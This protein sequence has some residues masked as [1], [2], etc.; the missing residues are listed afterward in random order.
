MGISESASLWV[1]I[2]AKVR[3]LTSES[4]PNPH[5]RDPQGVVVVVVFYTE[6]LLI[7]K[8]MLGIAH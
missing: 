2:P 6:H 7:H 1:A 4:P 5:K 3:S 8:I